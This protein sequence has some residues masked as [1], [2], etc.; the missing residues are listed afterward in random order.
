[1]EYILALDQGT[2][3]SRALLIDNKG[4]VKAKAQ[5]ELALLHKSV[6]G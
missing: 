5:K 2:T 1:M 3:S 4:Q 6:F